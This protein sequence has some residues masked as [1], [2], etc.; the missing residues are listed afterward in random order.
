MALCQAAAMRE[1]WKGEKTHGS[2]QSV[3]IFSNPEKRRIRKDIPQTCDIKIAKRW[4]TSSQSDGSSLNGKSCIKLHGNGNGNGN[5]NSTQTIAL[6]FRIYIQSVHV[7]SPSSGLRHTRTTNMNLFQSICLK[8]QWKKRLKA[9]KSF[10]LVCRRSAKAFALSAGPR[11]LFPIMI[12]FPN[13]W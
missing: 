10:N 4:S 11:Y 9:S 6:Q 13:R 8:N 5:G 2:F 1:L 3:C 12:I 7:G